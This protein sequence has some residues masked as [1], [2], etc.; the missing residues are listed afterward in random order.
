MK[1]IEMNRIR[2]EMSCFN[3]QQWYENETFES[4]ILWSS[5]DESEMRS[6]IRKIKKRQWINKN[7]NS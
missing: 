5:K 6:W 2:S 3:E 4:R 1:T 7:E